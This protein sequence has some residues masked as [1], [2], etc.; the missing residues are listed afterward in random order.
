MTVD[1]FIPVS[2]AVAEGNQL[3]KLEVPYRVIPNFVPDDISL[4]GD[5]TNPLLKKLPVGD[6][7]LFVGDL[8][9][10]KGIDVLLRAYAGMSSQIPLV[11]IGRPMADLCKNLPRNV[12]LL[13]SWPHEAVM[14]AWSRCTIALAPSI[15]ADPCP[16]VA[17]EAM[18]MG[19]PIVASRIGGLSDIVVDGETGFLVT[20]GDPEALR[21][22]MQCLLEDPTRREQMGI[23][24][25]QRVVEF[26]AG[27]VASGI[28]QVYRE[29]LAT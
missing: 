5:D 14:G 21:E 7:L 4:S 24:A 3:V 29:I 25:K 28:E 9:P 20:P 12:L 15:W 19:R 6:F 16:T 11:L 2:Q 8:S 17:M 26:Q 22:A 1:M 18:A 27:T 10:D 23:M 13:E